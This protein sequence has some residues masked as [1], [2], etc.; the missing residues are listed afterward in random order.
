L[1]DLGA[2]EEFLPRGSFGAFRVMPSPSFRTA[3]D[4]SVFAQEEKNRNKE[5]EN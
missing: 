5:K 4:R 1:A 3:C 2:G